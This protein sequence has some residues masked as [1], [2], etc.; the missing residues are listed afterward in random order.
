MPSAGSGA[1]GFLP[2]RASCAAR[3]IRSTRS[4]RTACAPSGRKPLTT[5][6]PGLPRASTL[7][8]SR[9]STGAGPRTPS[10]AAR[11]RA[12]PGLSNRASN[13]SSAPIVTPALR[14]RLRSSGD[15]PSTASRKAIRGAS[16]PA[17][18]NSPATT[19]KAGVA[20]G[21]RAISA[22]AIS[23]GTW[24]RSIAS[25]QRTSR[26]C[27][28]SRC[29]LARQSRSRSSTSCGRASERPGISLATP[30]P[31]QTIMPSTRVSA[32][33]SAAASASPRRPRSVTS[34]FSAAASNSRRSA[35]RAAGSTVKRKPS[36]RPI[37]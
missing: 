4:S 17:A 22:S 26:A 27:T 35:A 24:R 15:R 31:F 21:S 16:P 20:C 6:A 8:P 32:A 1:K 13:R 18:S 7:A 34:R 9:G 30:C 23:A 37:G 14:S 28:A 12:A 36:S 19:R 2:C 10:S 3:A 5:C 33:S 11:Q 25:N 29:G